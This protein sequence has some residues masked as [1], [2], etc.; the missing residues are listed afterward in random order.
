VARLSPRTTRTTRLRALPGSE[1]DD[2]VPLG[3]EL[4]TLR[5][6]RAYVRDLLSDPAFRVAYPRFPREVSLR[7]SRARHSRRW[8]SEAFYEERKIVL[9]PHHGAPALPHR[10]FERVVLH[11]LA[12][13][14]TP[15]SAPA[16][17]RRFAAHYLF[18]VAL[19]MGPDAARRLAL[20]GTA[21]V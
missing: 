11:E 21:G 6:T 1:W 15:P 3:R 4:P 20:G 18:L 9:S 8:Q 17:G 7:R 13:L 12:H 2:S 16:H 14:L 19:R 5:E 10:Y